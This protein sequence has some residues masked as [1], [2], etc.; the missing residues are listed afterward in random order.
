MFRVQIVCKCLGILNR[1][2]L[3]KMNTNVVITLDT[4]RQK[5]DQTYPLIMRLGHNGRT[6][7][8]PLGIN[9]LEKDWDTN[10]KQVKKTYVGVNTVSRLNNQI[11]KRKADAMDVI[12]KLN[13]SKQLI[14]MSVTTL[15][16]RITQQGAT[17][18]VFKY[19]E[20]VIADL[21]SSKRIGTARSYKGVLNILRS[22]THG[23]DL[24]FTD[25]TFP[26]LQ[27]L[28]VD[29]LG[30]GNG[31][32]GLAVYLR[33]IK[34][35]YNRAIKEG[36][37]E[38]EFYP[39]SA[40]KIKTAPTAK[41]SLPGSQLAKIIT[42]VLE[43]SHPLF[44]ARNYFVASYL[45]YGMNFA[46]MAYL[47]KTD[48]VEGRVQYRRK[49]TAKLYDIKITDS[50]GRILSYYLDRFSDSEYV[51]PILKRATVEMQAKDILWARKRYNTRLKKLGALCGILTPLT[52]YVSR[53]SFATQAMMLEVPV[54]AISTMLGHSSIKTT[55][56]YLNSLPSN[57]LDSYN[58][59]ITG[60]EENTNSPET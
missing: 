17:Q 49:K 35:L 23:K 60:I 27:S 57:M 40:Y 48:L 5:K 18:S 12:F 55:E 15:R 53:H 34:A 46:D 33:T 24:S 7:S 54:K 37:V 36:I 38:K 59:K 6:T 50:L 28:E 52:S 43:E 29:H 21:L 51:F 30:K 44:H 25:I 31:L 3:L 9:L 14:S 2:I 11:Q 56:V 39:F 47:K 19:T 22:F 42:Y 1:Q 8:I 16:D 58:A 10:T 20:Q 45:M 13:E 41:R 32:N 26:F 4:R